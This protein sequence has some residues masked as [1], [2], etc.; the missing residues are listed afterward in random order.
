MAITKNDLIKEVAIYN[1]K[2]CK[3]TKH[4]LTV[5]GAYGGYQVQLRGK[6]R[7]NGKGYRG[8]IGS[9]AVDI[10]PGFSSPRVT[11]MNLFKRDSKG[12][13]RDS[14]KHYEKKSRNNW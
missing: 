5:Q 2:Y 11:L 1:A 13:V 12:E 4:E 10:T 6:K 3:N 7:K 8:Y 14:I 9:G